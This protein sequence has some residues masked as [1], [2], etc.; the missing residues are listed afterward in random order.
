VIAEVIASACLVGTPCDSSFLTCRRTRISNWPEHSSEHLMGACP[1]LAEAETGREY[2]K[3]RPQRL[4]LP[5][6]NYPTSTI[7]LFHKKNTQRGLAG[8]FS[9]ASWVVAGRHGCCLLGECLPPHGSAGW[10]LASP[11]S[12]ITSW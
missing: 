7:H 6:Q 9:S 2:G 12:L 3:R 5:G 10:H 11:Y 4:G 1:S 8:R